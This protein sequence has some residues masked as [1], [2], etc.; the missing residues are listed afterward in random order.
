MKTFKK[1]VVI[2]LLLILSINVYSQSNKEKVKNGTILHCWCWSFNTIK[3]NIPDIAA[4]GFKAL[5]TSPINTC[6]EGDEKGMELM[7]ETRTGGKWYYH[8]QPT[9][10]KI[11]NYQLGTRDEFKAMCDEAEKYG[12]SVIVDVLPNHTSS[13]LPDVLPEYIEAVGGQDKLL[14]ENGMRPISNWSDRYQGTTGKMGGLP[15]V[16]TENPLFQAYFMAFMNDAIECGADGFRFDTAKHIGLPDD[17]KDKYS[18]ENDFW[19]IFTGKK[20]INGVMLSNADDLFLYGEVLQ[21]ANARE[22]DYTEYLSVTAS[23]YGSR[24]RNAVA[25]GVFLP[26]TLSNWQHP[27]SGDKLI[28]WVES[29]DT[30][31]NQGESAKLTNFQLRAGWA[32]IASKK[33]GTPLFFN[34]PQGKE[35][36]QF[37]GVS[38]IGDKGNDE[39]KHPEIIAVNNF[40]DAM[41][42]EDEELLNGSTKETLIIKRGNKGV[43][44]INL[45]K[46]FEKIKLPVGLADGKYKDHANKIN[47]TVKNGI[48]TG[49][50]N[51]S[52]IAVIY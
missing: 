51:P 33:D 40:R 16:N 2:F 37:P 42:G 18:V 29:H 35:A 32:V 1:L 14:H 13:Y 49:N 7:S 11:G 6:R 44:I 19:P 43:V 24:L 23:N 20:D 4:A 46:G 26:V 52:K 50:M 30:Y 3:E 27:A 17:P 39:F 48:L 22:E 25:N 5:Q 34:R 45:K 8:Y 28:T 15:D 41:L 21:G 38:K 47:F 31:A 9:A 36:T 12:I 10:W